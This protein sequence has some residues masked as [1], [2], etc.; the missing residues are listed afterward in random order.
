MRKRQLTIVGIVLIA[1]MILFAITAFR[2]QAQDKT[3][4]Q[5]DEATVVKK[6]QVTDKE[7]ELARNIK[8]CIHIVKGKN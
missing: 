2:Q 5:Q 7:R 1:A 8:S 4:P 3:K 6:G